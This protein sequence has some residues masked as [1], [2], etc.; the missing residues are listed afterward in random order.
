MKGFIEV[1]A[2]QILN[3]VSSTYASSNIKNKPNALELAGF[4]KFASE[5]IYIIEKIALILYPTLS[6]AINESQ[7]DK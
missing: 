2:D 3:K 1:E 5:F 7:Q 4:I 6:K